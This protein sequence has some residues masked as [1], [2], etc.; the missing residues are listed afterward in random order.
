MYVIREANIHAYEFVC[1]SIPL[2]NECAQIAIQS[3][4]FT[5]IGC[6]LLCRQYSTHRFLLVGIAGLNSY[7]FETLFLYLPLR[8]LQVL[9]SANVG[10]LPLVILQVRVYTCVQNIVLCSF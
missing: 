9:A 5:E 3:P 4:D 10:F 1:E 2:H 6:W 7:Y 8:H